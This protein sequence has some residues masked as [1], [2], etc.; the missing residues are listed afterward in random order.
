M[1]KSITIVNTQYLAILFSFLFMV[2][3]SSVLS[4]PVK[5]V[6]IIPLQMNSAQDLSFLQKGL[7][8]ML[9]SR[10]ADPGKV[11]ALER[12]T[13]DT[14]LSQA[15][16][17]ALTKGSLNESKARLI[18]KAL[19]VDH[20]LFGSI[21]MFGNSASLDIS[22]VDVKD[23]KPALKFSRQTKQ[24]GAVITE[25]DSIATQINLKV[26]NRKPETFLPEE[27]YAKKE[28]PYQPG[29][30]ERGILTNFQSLMTIKDEII[31]VCSADVTG[32]KKTE[33]VVAYDH[34]IE[35]FRDNLKGRLKSI[36]KI[37]G[38]QYLDII[39]VD[40]ADIDKNGKA[41]IFITRIRRE[42]GDLESQVLEY[43][44]KQFLAK[45]KKLGWYFRV[46]GI[47]SE[48]E[49]PVLYGQKKGPFGPYSGGRVFKMNFE[50]GQ[51]V[52]G[53]GLR[54]P[55]GF[56]VMSL[57]TAQFFAEDRPGFLYTDKKG[58]LVIF[59]DTGKVEWE[60][61]Y[62]FGGS[63]LFYYFAKKDDHLRETF[64]EKTD[65]R[66]VFFQPGNIVADVDSDGKNEI[67]A[68][69]NHDSA[70]NTFKE[71]RRFKKGSLDILSWSE[72]GLSSAYIPKNLPGQITGMT[73]ADFNSDGVKEL[74]VTMIRKKSNFNA[75]DSR[76]VI[77]AYDFFSK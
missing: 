22:M 34:G 69:K 16:F 40:A 48:S 46:T 2:C 12:E 14:A 59:N 51:Y 38:P 76:S 13:I 1:R 21:T 35:I 7:F 10:L 71:V 19:G 43:D 11:E 27:Y 52:P 17:S 42:T 4:E 20:I 18:G 61:D 31:A 5:K 66:G 44:N 68:I 58:R 15:Q 45:V 3:A 33:I 24:P 8:S 6:A 63:K 65:R 62:G 74:I 37:E 55:D 32:D 23:D 30:V 36:K 73:I 26:Y 54:V 77:L 53:D 47:N 67:I 28:Q 57:V 75:K 41:E 56:N 64:V 9:S 49:T 29:V 39:G 72:M 60:S 50:N 70:E 25:M